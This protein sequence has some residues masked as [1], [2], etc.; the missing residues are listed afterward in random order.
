MQYRR[1][2]STD[3]RVSAVG[4]GAWQFA[5]VWGKNFTQAEVDALLSRARELGVN[6]IDTAECYGKDHLSE[7]LIGNAIAGRRDEWV[8]ATKFGHNPGNALGD[9]NFSPAQVQLQLEESLRALRTDY[10]DVYQLHSAPDALFANDALWTMLDAQVRAGKVRF[11][12]NSIGLPNQAGQV[13]QSARYGIRVVQTIYNAVRPAAQTHVLPVAE[14]QDLGVVARV[15]LA[16]GFLAGGYRPGHSFA[17]DDVRS[18]RPQEGLDREIERALDFL[19]DKPDGIAA[20]TWAIAWCLRQPRVGTV[21]P[22]IKSLAQLE[23]NAAAGDL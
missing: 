13:E 8:I 5:G 19:R 22:G 3:L 1:L 20:S 21:I 15:P 7:R 9:E 12:G 6:F 11:L 18:W 14:A 16:S 2:G 17:Q 23:E 10:I 4:F